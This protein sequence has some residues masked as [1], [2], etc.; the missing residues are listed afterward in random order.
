MS[1]ETSASEIEKSEIEKA[2]KRTP[3]GQDHHGFATA[4]LL[5]T[6]HGNPSWLPRLSRKP[7]NTRSFSSFPSLQ[8]PGA[9]NSTLLFRFN[10]F[11]EM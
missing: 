5:T 10:L 11:V 8:N 9:M 4:G 2:T 3:V 1:E 6:R 7:T